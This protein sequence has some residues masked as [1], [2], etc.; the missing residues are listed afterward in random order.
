M[1]S[2][3][4][5]TV[6]CEQSP[7]RYQLSRLNVGPTAHVSSIPQGHNRLGSGGPPGP[8]LKE[9]NSRARLT[10]DCFFIRSVDRLTSCS[11]LW[12]TGS[13]LAPPLL[14]NSCFVRGSSSI[15]YRILSSSKPLIWLQIF[16]QQQSSWIKIWSQSTIMLRRLSKMQSTPKRRW[17]K[18]TRP[19]PLRLRMSNTT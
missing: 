3:S 7:P 17:L 13:V 9:L 18:R 15:T 16:S 6:S 2:T 8:G 10:A 12:T 5:S 11:I 1:K 14:F 4:V 19:A